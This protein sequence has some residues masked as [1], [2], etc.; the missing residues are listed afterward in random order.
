MP[1]LRLSRAIDALLNDRSREV[2]EVIGEYFADDYRQ[3]TGGQWADRARFAE[4]MEV[5][6]GL[7]S[8]LVDIT[9]LDDLDAADGLGFAERHLLEFDVDGVRHRRESYVFGRR[10]DDGRFAVVEEVTLA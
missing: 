5:V 10:G 6:R 4:M 2:D 3:R 8:D 9:V 7:T 1:P